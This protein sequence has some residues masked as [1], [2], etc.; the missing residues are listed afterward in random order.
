MKDESKGLIAQALSNYA[1]GHGQGLNAGTYGMSYYP[2]Y[3][4]PRPIY[5]R[6]DSDRD[7]QIKAVKAILGLK[8]DDSDKVEAIQAILK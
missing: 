4:E 6:F 2:W 3:V 1:V 5:Y 7:A 8:I